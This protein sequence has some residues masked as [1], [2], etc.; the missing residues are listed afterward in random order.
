MSSTATVRL[1]AGRE[2]RERLEGRLLRV[3]T[4]LTALLVV[5]GVVIPALVHSH[6]VTRLGLVGQQA[7]AMATPLQRTAH[8]A[9]LS[10]RLVNVPDNSTAKAL[11]RGGRLNA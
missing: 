2:I 6:H 3:M 1:I 10:V 9:K 8:A 5:A 11:L 7:R 4:G